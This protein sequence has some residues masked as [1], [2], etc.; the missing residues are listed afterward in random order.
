[1]RH[2]WLNRLIL[3]VGVLIAYFSF[4]MSGDDSPLGVVAGTIVAAAGLV[5][6]AYVVVVEIRRGEKRLQPVQLLLLV[7][8]AVV[9]FAWVCYAVAI[10]DP[11]QF[12]GLNTRLDGLYFSM[13]TVSTVGY[14]DVSAVGQ[15]ARGLVLVQL[16]FNIAF[17]AA[18]VGM[19]RETVKARQ[20]GESE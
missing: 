16:V 2:P 12:N 20:R 17:I 1:M 7:E 10:H 19:F 5:A 14:G 4:P 9:I 6:V 8:L 18:I 15:L 13:T 11:T 3:P